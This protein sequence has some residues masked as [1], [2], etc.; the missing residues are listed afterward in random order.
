MLHKFVPAFTLILL[1]G[2]VPAT[3]PS[4]NDRQQALNL[5]DQGTL[6]LRQGEA[7]KAQAAFE[8]ANELS[9]SGAALDGLGCV[10]FAN[11]DLDLAEEFFRAAYAYYPEYKNSLGNLASVLARKGK[12]AAATDLYVLAVRENPENFRFRNNF[13]GHL[14][15]L[16]QEDYR[17]QAKNEMWKAGALS[18][19]PT[20]LS[21]MELKIWD[22]Q[23][24]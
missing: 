20:V 3:S 11:G 8:L 7:L 12:L 15:D 9:P 1:F 23:K 19:H 18:K 16:K 21:N 5:I 13:A 24:N 22:S 6:L 14:V 4:L 2:C 10:A 17:E